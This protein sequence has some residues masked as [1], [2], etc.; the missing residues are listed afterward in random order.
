[1]WSD[2][3]FTWAASFLFRAGNDGPHL[4]INRVSSTCDNPRKSFQKSQFQS[5]RDKTRSKR[6]ALA[7]REREK[8]DQLF[9]LNYWCVNVKHFLL[10]FIGTIANFTTHRM[11]KRRKSLRLVRT[12]KLSQSHK[13]RDCF[14]RAPGLMFHGCY[15][16]FWEQ[17]FSLAVRNV[18]K[19]IWGR[20]DRHLG[21]E[22]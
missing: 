11:R 8:S 19:M 15:R 4:S 18:A 3:L 20:G 17:S 22:I 16:L 13:F 6:Q 5:E 7:L 1:M 9:L 2:K 14:L 12:I 10:C 21:H